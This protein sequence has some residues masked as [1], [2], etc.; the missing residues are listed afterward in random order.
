MMNVRNAKPHIGSVIEVERR[1]LLDDDVMERCRALLEERG[2]LVFPKLHLTD[3]EQLAFTDK[4]GTRINFVTRTNPAGGNPDVY[5][6]SLD[7]QINPQPEYVQGTFFWHM[8]GLNSPINPPKASLLSARRVALKG[9]QTEFANTYA[10]YASLPAAEKS[11]LAELRV[12]HSLAASLRPV[13]EAPTVDDFKRWRESPQNVHPLI[14]THLSGRKSLVIGST[15]DKVLGM[16]VPDGRS[17]LARLLE[18][19]AQPDFYY[20]HEWQM[21]DFVIWDNC[22]TLHRVIP[23][24]RNSGRLMHRTSIAGTESVH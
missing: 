14:W 5:K 6:I 24:D 21:G 1:H 12:Q 23:Y 13:V 19:T 10:A 3:D 18:W 2:V 4:F 22:G 17:L 16:P 20:R 11:E 7:P 8:D 9:G 15:A